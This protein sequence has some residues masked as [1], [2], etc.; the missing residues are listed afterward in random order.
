MAASTASLRLPGFMV[1]DMASLLGCL[2]PTPRLHFLIS[3]FTPINKGPDVSKNEY[4]AE[5][6]VRE[7]NEGTERVTKTSALSVM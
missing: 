3:A 1:N 4:S 5:R 6:A 7:M 2:V